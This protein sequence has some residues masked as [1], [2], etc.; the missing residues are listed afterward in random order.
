MKEGWALENPLA[1][2][3]LIIQDKRFL[4]LLSELTK[5]S[6]FLKLRKRVSVLTAE[7]LR[8]FLRVLLAMG[9]LYKVDSKKDLSSERN[10]I[11]STWEL[12]D[13]FFHT[14]TRLGRN[15]G[16]LGG[17]YRFKGK[18]PEPPFLK[19]LPSKRPI[20]LEK[21]NLKQILRRDPSLAQILEQRCSIRHHG[22]PPL[23]KKM[24]SEFLYRTAR[25]KEGNKR[26]SRPYPSGGALY[27]LEIYPVI[28]RCEGLAKGLYYYS[29]QGHKLY[30]ISGKTKCVLQLLM[31]AKISC[32]MKKLPQCLLVITARFQKVAWKYEGVAYSLILK[33]LG[34]LYQTMYLVATAMGLAPCAVGTGNS[35]LFSKAA[36]TNYYQET[37]VGEFI[38][39]SRQ[40]AK[41]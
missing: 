41:L 36:K 5:P 15:E 3:R 9:I 31:D 25:I 21:P 27:P 12:H 20:S 18:V 26:H 34:G 6:S 22:N 33:D 16:I 40:P 29:P 1:K 37:S 35:D 2:S 23:T 13:L 39:G 11:M 17:S 32:G 19:P 14:R 28:H 24:L 7:E 8:F 10:K 38:L 4:F 30:K